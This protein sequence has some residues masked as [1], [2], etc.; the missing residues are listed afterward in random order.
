MTLGAVTT[1]PDRQRSNR[2]DGENCRQRTATSGRLEHASVKCDEVPAIYGDLIAAIWVPVGIWSIF[3]N[4][5][6]T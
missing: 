6:K 2:C 3:T 5:L 4:R 1:L